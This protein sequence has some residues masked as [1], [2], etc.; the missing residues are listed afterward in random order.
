MDVKL[1]LPRKRNFEIV[2]T[3]YGPKRVVS[4][5]TMQRALAA[6]GMRFAALARKGAWDTGYGLWDL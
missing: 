4:P 5:E 6:A 1:P 2:M 3:R